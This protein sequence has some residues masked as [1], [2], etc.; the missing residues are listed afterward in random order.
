MRDCRDAARE[1]Y[2]APLREGIVGLGRKVF[3]ADF[4][5]ELDDDLGIATR[6]LDGRTLPYRSLSVG[7]REQLG[8]LARLACALLVDPVEGVPLLFDDTLGHADPER[9][10]AMAGVLALAGDRCQIIVLTCMPDRFAQVA[11][12]RVVQ[13]R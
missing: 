6:T 2:S 7:A 1:A 3:G 5:V 10:R 8:V 12:A 9:L 4:A 11:G 13:I